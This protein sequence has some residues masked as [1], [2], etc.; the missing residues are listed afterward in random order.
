M[1][2]G[3]VEPS[4]LD[5][6]ETNKFGEIVTAVVEE[7]GVGVLLVEHNMNLIGSVCREVCVVDF[8]QMIFCGS[9]ADM[10]RNEQV[11]AAYLGSSGTELD[12]AAIPAAAEG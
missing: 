5:M 7:W 11:R 1:S 3:R 2:L 12:E 9:V 4:G 6:A 10:H 8:G